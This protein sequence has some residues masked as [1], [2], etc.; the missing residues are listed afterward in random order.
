MTK[1]QRLSK[2]GESLHLKCAR[3]FLRVVGNF[4]LKQ[5]DT[6]EGIV[7]AVYDSEED[8][9]RSK[10][11]D[12]YWKFTIYQAGKYWIFQYL[13]FT[14]GNYKCPDDWDVRESDEA[15]N[16][17]NLCAHHLAL[18]IQKQRVDDEQECL[19]EVLSD[20]IEDFYGDDK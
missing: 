14:S 3:R 20:C 7:I 6:K 8:F 12:D 10:N 16:T 9:K 15:Y 1:I 17:F 13:V 18:F 19:G 11:E 4:F 2:A 5:F